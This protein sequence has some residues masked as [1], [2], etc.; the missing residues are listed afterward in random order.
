MSEAS[1]SL[2]VGSTHELTAALIPS[3]ATNNIIIWESSD[4]KVTLDD[5]SGL[6]CTVTGVSAGL[7]T[8][9]ATTADGGFEAVCNVTVE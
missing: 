7:C 6:T 9:T 8:V 2:A 5:D 3:N 1:I 4:G